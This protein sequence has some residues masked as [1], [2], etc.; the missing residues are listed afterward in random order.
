MPGSPRNN[1]D[2]NSAPWGRWVDQNIDD[3]NTALGRN[4][5]DQ[6]NNNKQL[7]SS[8]NVIGQ[9]IQ[10]LQDQQNILAA[11]Q[12]TL[13]DQQTLLASQQS[14]LNSAVQ[15]IANQQGQINSAISTLQSQQNYLASL[16]PVN[17]SSSAS[18]TP[19]SGGWTNNGTLRPS[20]TT[21]TTANGKIRVSLSAAIIGCYGA[22]SISSPS[23][24]SFSRDFFSPSSPGGVNTLFNGNTQGLA[25]TREWYVDVPANIQVTVFAEF[26]A[27]TASAQAAYPNISVQN[28][29]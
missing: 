17:N 15:N 18:L 19:I 23:G 5:Q 21:T 26:Y 24:Y 11:Q 14:T 16:R 25:A 10:A 6:L 8:I 1:L 9:Q 4:G 12:Q 28:V 2:S 22:F 13:A 29:S 3:I 20:V 7:N 27:L